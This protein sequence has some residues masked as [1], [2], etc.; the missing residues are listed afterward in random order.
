MS[1]NVTIVV[2]ILIV[3]LLA[4]YM[5]WLRNKWIETN[6]YPSPSPLSTVGASPLVSP[7]LSPSASTSATTKSTTGSGQLRTASPSARLR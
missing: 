1:R 5:V 4:A 2:I 7:S 3:V 6:I